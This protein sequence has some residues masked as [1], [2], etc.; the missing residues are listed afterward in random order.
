MEVQLRGFSISL[1]Q[2]IGHGSSIDLNN[3]NFHFQNLE[4]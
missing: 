3:P 2:N 1:V 4:F